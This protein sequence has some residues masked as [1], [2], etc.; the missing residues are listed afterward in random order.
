V[1]T[2]QRTSPTRSG[3]RPSLAQELAREGDLDVAEPA[4]TTALAVE[5]VGG[6]LAHAEVGHPHLGL[7]AP[8]Q[9]EPGRGRRLERSTVGVVRHD[10][11]RA[12]ALDDQEA[13]RALVGVEQLGLELEA[14]AGSST[15]PLLDQDPVE[16]VEPR[17]RARARSASPP[18]AA[19]EPD[20]ASCCPAVT[21]SSA[22]S[23]S[24]AAG[25]AAAAPT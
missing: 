19:A 15:P 9:A 24:A 5:T 11:A 21:P 23:D 14:Q 1:G 10:A 18:S 20:A 13:V 3:S 22:A 17:A 7:R 16:R 12:V 25:R 2:R 4:L 6:V 8:G